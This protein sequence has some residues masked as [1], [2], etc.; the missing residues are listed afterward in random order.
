MREDLRKLIKLQK[1]GSQV[2]KPVS[3][4][5]SESKDTQPKN[6]KNRNNN[7]NAK[8]QENLNKA[9]SFIGI[10]KS[11]QNPY[12]ASSEYSDEYAEGIDSQSFSEYNSEE[13]QAQNQPVSEKW[14][15]GLGRVVSKTGTEFAKGL[16]YLGGVIPA[17]LDQDITH[18]TNNWFVDIFQEME[19]STKE[20]LPVYVRE[21]VENGS[22]ARQIWSPEFW[23][24]EGADGFGFFLSAMLSGG[25]TS[26][27]TKSAQI[28]TKLAG[29]ISKGSKLADKADNAIIAA[30]QTFMESAA[31]TKGMV[32]NL[33]SH[34]ASKAVDGGYDSGKL[35]D[36]GNKI[37]YSQKEVD[38]MIG[39]AAISTLGLN[40]LFLIGPNTLQSKYL[41]GKGE[42]SNSWMSKLDIQSPE[43]MKESFEKIIPWKHGL[44]NVLGKGSKSAS[45]EA[46][47]ELSQFSIE[48]YESKKGKGLTNKN[49][50]EGMASGYFEGITSIEGQKSMFLGA[51]LGL[52]PGVVGAYKQ[53]K[54]EKKQTEGLISLLNNSKKAFKDEITSIYKKN[55]DGSIKLKEGKAQIDENKF[56]EM[57][58]SANEDN[59]LGLMYNSAKITGNTDVAK[60]ILADMTLRHLYPYLEI[61]GGFEIWKKHLDGFSEIME[62]DY[63]DLGFESKKDYSAFMHNIGQIANKESIKVK[64]R[65]PSFYGINVKEMNS[66][67][68]DVKTLNNEL[69]KFISEVEYNAVRYKV[70]K[71]ANNKKIIDINNQ[72][73]IIEK[74]DAEQVLNIDES[75]SDTLDSTKNNRKEHEHL[76][77]LKNQLEDDNKILDDNYESLFNKVKQQSAFNIRI[78]KKIEEQKAKEEAEIKGE[79]S[80]ANPSE[81]NP[82]KKQLISDFYENLKT[83]GYK[84]EKDNESNSDFG[85]GLITLKDNDDNIY[86]VVRFFN[87]K[88]KSHDYKLIN[89]S[90]NSEQNFTID[91][92]EKLGLNKL[93]NILSREEFKKWSNSK[94]I[95]EKNNERL[96]TLRLVIQKHFNNRKSKKNRLKELQDELTIYEKELE[97]WVKLDP[98]LTI[99]SVI[100]EIIILESKIELINKESEL[101]SNDL[102]ELNKTLGL[103]LDM[104][105]EIIKA[106]NDES[107]YSFGI[108]LN[109]LRNQVESGEFEKDIS[110]VEESIILNEIISEELEAK[111]RRMND[112]L[113]DLYSEIAKIQDIQ[114]ILNGTKIPLYLQEAIRSAIP[115]IVINNSVIQELDNSQIDDLLINPSTRLELIKALKREKSQLMGAYR[116]GKETLIELENNFKTIQ[117]KIKD[118]NSNKFLLDRYNKLLINYNN[119]KYVKFGK[120]V[121]DSYKKEKEE[122][123]D[124]AINEEQEQ[125]KKNNVMST[126]SNIYKGEM[127]KNGNWKPEK[128][129]GQKVLNDNYKQGVRWDETTGDIPLNELD[130]YG[131]RFV[132]NT[133]LSELGEVP[134]SDKSDDIY[135]VL[136]NRESNQPVKNGEH[137]VFTGMPF[138]STYF[139]ENGSS[140]DIER[141]P[142][143]SQYNED[144]IDEDNTVIFENEE[145]DDRS[146]LIEAITEHL[147]DKYDVFRNFI[148]ENVSKSSDVILYGISDIS[149]GIPIFDDTK[150]KPNDVLDIKSIIIPNSST[151]TKSN[152]SLMKVQPGR[153]YVETKNGQFVRVYNKK[154]SDLEEKEKG[155]ILDSIIEFM[156]IAK[157]VKDGNFRTEF[158]FKG[159]NESIPLRGDDQKGG[160][161]DYFINWGISKEKSYGIDIF[162]IDN[163]PLSG[164]EFRFKMENKSHK[165]NID[166]LFDSN[167]NVK[168]HSDSSLIPLVVF[169]EN[170]YLNV[171][172]KLLESKGKFK[173]P[174]KFDSKKMELT[175]DIASSANDY[176]INNY[177]YTNIKKYDKE[178]DEIPN[179]VNKYISYETSEL[180]KYKKEVKSKNTKV[181]NK[182][183]RLKENKKV[184]KEPFFKD[185]A[186]LDVYKD[187]INQGFVKEDS[188]ILNK[189]YDNFNKE[190]FD[191]SNKKKTVCKKVR[192]AGSNRKKRNK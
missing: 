122:Q 147:K 22:F 80:D 18:M 92:L 7:S 178:V 190:S 100:E 143:Y 164:Y 138:T 93:E 109:E 150:K 54:T 35:D 127:L 15:H 86:R 39:N 3:Q 189:M 132:N 155:R 24:T 140:I 166:D 87:K 95:L 76:S 118:L 184:S 97:E 145:F 175:Y 101:I 163:N 49:V 139:R 112:S 69:K 26:A 113:D 130:K 104:H 74:E 158:K 167:G 157:Y 108:K 47:E 56:I 161:L 174:N 43:M 116:V 124:I 149:A 131:L 177:L 114:S 37:L 11:L 192:R 142:E 68:V 123:D 159:T 160:I 42:S 30:T 27:I 102:I 120:K 23:V 183:A 78:N 6:K 85:K 65:G 71:E 129:N 81:I 88:T 133:Q 19:D 70:L 77:K 144:I 148:L 82:E 1:P 57:L 2:A 125:L 137:V 186:P 44:K 106:I 52:G 111:I 162:S 172:N 103:M 185:E 67:N 41:F 8:A 58:D 105:S 59:V 4:L 156:S 51:V 50:I 79:D 73:S 91:L 153:I 13:L 75:L 40:A 20:S 98:E 107:E 170:K 121:N 117:D 169:L 62:N 34:W 45:S 141:T 146:D 191:D 28:G 33:K 60:K 63:K 136:Y 36:N 152:N 25:A 89:L 9:L 180:P 168:K 154:I 171:N 16:G 64:D 176:Y 38:E 99:D 48:D 5:T 96:N 182:L 128:K 10:D 134:P 84:I 32:D 53:N 21:S 14:L 29:M 151:I 83:K 115:E 181:G 187:D 12:L 179:F 66:L 110:I 94:R 55:E 165:M 188:G 31:E 173:V 17:F 72:L 135:V 61:E 46:F 119:L 126:S 90:D